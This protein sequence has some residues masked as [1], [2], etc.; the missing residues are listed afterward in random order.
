M[1]VLTSVEKIAVQFALSSSKL[2]AVSYL[3]TARETDKESQARQQAANNGKLILEPDSDRVIDLSGLQQNLNEQ[4]YTLVGAK[5]Q[6]RQNLS[7]YQRETYLVR[8][9]FELNAKETDITVM[10]REEFDRM[11]DMSFWH[12]CSYMNPSKSSPDDRAKDWVSVNLTAR[13]QRFVG[14]DPTHPILVSQRDKYGN[15]TSAKAPITAQCSMSVAGGRPLLKK[16]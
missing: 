16:L 3:P 6:V 7:G 11:T 5:I 14:E 12:A 4:N 2:T 13:V 15:K 8:F 9:S 10:A 1:E